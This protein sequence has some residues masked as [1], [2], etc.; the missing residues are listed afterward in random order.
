MSFLRML[1][2]QNNSCRY[3]RNRGAELL[4]Y[5]FVS[6]P[7]A[8]DCRSVELRALCNEVPRTP[9]GPEGSNGTGYASGA[10]DHPKLLS[11][12]T[13]FRPEALRCKARMETRSAGVDFVL[14]VSREGQR[15]EVVSGR[16][17]VCGGKEGIH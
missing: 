15:A 10:A 16:F 11:P 6:S 2:R 14:R 7:A 1:I 12:R 4:C 13:V 17:A 8:R 9:P 3:P 5:N